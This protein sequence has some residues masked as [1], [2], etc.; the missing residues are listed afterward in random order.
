MQGFRAYTIK[1]GKINQ[2]TNDDTEVWSN[3]KIG[4]L[5]KDELRFAINEKLTN[6]LGKKDKLRV[7]L[8]VLDNDEYDKLLILTDGVTDCCSDEKI[9]LICN[10]S[11][12]PEQLAKQIINE[13]VYSE[14]EK[15]NPQSKSTLTT[16]PGKDNATALVLVKNNK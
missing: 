8:V 7:D 15:L 1:D 2:V 6:A 11:N 14:P 4:M 12:N 16:N 13:A 3:Y 9:K 5:S 10:S